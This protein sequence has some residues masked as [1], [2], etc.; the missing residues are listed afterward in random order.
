MTVGQPAQ[1]VRPLVH[2]ARGHAVR[3]LLLQLGGQVDRALAHR[4]PVTHGDAHVVEH[5]LG[6]SG[7]VVDAILAQGVRL[8]F[9]PG[10]RLRAGAGRQVVVDLAI[11]DLQQPSGLVAPHDQLRVQ[12]EVDG[13]V[14]GSQ[15]ADQGV[16]DERHVVG[17][18]L[19]NL[20]CVRVAR[21]AHDGA[22]RRAGGAHL[23]HGRRD[24]FQRVGRIVVDII[25]R[26]IAWQT[27]NEHA[28]TRLECVAHV[29]P[30]PVRPACLPPP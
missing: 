23:E 21:D 4:I 24:A 6:V 11:Q 26:E 1:K 14:L 28:C 8:Q 17:D 25:R 10:P 2:H 22:P 27:G 16:H 18:G 20:G 13:A 3:W 29:S 12:Q 15:E 5:P 9:D 19:Q 30:H 7:Q